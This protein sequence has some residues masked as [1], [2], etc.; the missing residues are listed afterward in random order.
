MTNFNDLVDQSLEAYPDK[1]EI[2]RLCKKYIKQTGKDFS[3]EL[4]YSFI[5]LTKE[6]K[7][8]SNA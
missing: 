8:E 1:A 2:E 5:N 3:S 7:D 6:S 4:F